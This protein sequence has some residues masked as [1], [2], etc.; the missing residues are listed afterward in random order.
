VGALR[1][2]AQ[3]IAKFVVR[4]EGLTSLTA[5]NRTMADDDDEFNPTW[6]S[7]RGSPELGGLLTALYGNPR[8]TIN[9][10]KPK[11]GSPFTPTTT[12]N[13]SGATRGFST[14][15]RNVAVA[16]PRVGGGGSGSGSGSSSSP[17]RLA[18]VDCIARRRQASRIQ[19]EL[20]QAKE[21]QRHY[22]APVAHRAAG[23]SEKER[24][25]QIFGYKGGK[26]L[27]EE[28]TCPAGDAPFEIM[29]KKRERERLAKVLERRNPFGASCPTAPAPLSELEQ[30]KEQIASEIN[31]RRAFLQDMRALGV[32]AQVRT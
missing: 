1:F 11:Q 5:E 6:Q 7:F 29:A 14:T 27:P 28:L 20:E 15:R 23:D 4:R 13:S 31:E 12:F 24:L 25:S 30:L 22:R 21:Q 26:A 17:T 18:P 10:P 16:V 9:Y 19:E 3:S 32:P 8:A 2:G